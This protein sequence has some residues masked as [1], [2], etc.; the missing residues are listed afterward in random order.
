MAD[1][2][3]SL[4]ACLFPFRLFPLCRSFLAYL[5]TGYVRRNFGSWGKGSVIVYKAAYMLG[6][7]YVH[8][9]E[10]TVIEKEAC[11]TAYD[12]YNGGKQTFEPCIRIGN[13]C[14][15][16][17]GAHITAI[18]G[19]EIGD[20]LLTGSNVLITDNS[21]GLFHYAMME[22]PPVERPLK[23]KGKVR[24]GAN[25]WIGNNVCVLPGVTIGDGAVI[26]ANSVVTHDVPPCSMAGG[27]PARVIKQIS[28]P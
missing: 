18:D 24:I 7:K 23:S 9:G 26:A 10:G 11:I 4:A 20:H 22:V 3:G 13:Q 14:H 5:Y 16:G 17:I 25:V 2:I 6:L 15:I 21:H 28:C 12:S 19:I 8:V 1:A 27:M